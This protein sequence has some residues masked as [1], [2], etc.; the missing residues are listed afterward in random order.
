MI[1]KKF[2]FMEIITQTRIII[3]FLLIINVKIQMFR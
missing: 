3:L 1:E 2:I